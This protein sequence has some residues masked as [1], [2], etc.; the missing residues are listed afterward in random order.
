MYIASKYLHRTNPHV[1]EFFG[2]SRIEGMNGTF[3]VVLGKELKH[4]YI[5]GRRQ[6]DKEIYQTTIK[7]FG[8][9]E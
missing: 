1:P 4:L 3:W 9:L 5:M 2:P 7:R 8:L 6:I